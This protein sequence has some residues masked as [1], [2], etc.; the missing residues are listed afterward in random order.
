M[1]LVVRLHVKMTFSSVNR[2]WL[3]PILVLLC[4]SLLI[5]L[6]LV[7]FLLDREREKR[8]SKRW[9]TG[10]ISLSVRE[11]TKTMAFFFFTWVIRISQKICLWECKWLRDPPRNG[12]VKH[13]CIMEKGSS[14]ES[15]GR[16]QQQE[17]GGKVTFMY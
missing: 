3:A 12:R 6:V 1:C 8:Q 7:F 17:H 4:L 15:N 10:A 5:P 13:D 16:K 11:Q 14:G 2:I 9:V